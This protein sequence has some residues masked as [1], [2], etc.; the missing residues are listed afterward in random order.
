MLFSVNGP[1][2]AERNQELVQFVLDR[3]R[4]FLPSKY[5]L[6]LTIFR[7][8]HARA[9]GVGFMA[10]IFTGR[11]TFTSEV[12]HPPFAMLLTIDSPLQEDA[13][14]ISHF[15]QFGYHQKGDVNIL[16]SSGEGHTPYPGDYR[17]EDQVQRDVMRNRSESS[18]E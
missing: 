3:E 6:Y 4:K 8:P 11:L 1:G 18:A 2:F 5:D 10:N 7:G 16:L 17:T 12:A 13:G 15:G 9:S 14:R